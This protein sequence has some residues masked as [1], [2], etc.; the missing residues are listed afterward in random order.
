MFCGADLHEKQTVVV[1]A[2]L[3]LPRFIALELL[4]ENSSENRILYN[5]CA[6]EVRE[7]LINGTSIGR[8]R[9]VSVL[10]YSGSHYVADVLWPDNQQKWIRFDGRHPYNGLGFEVATPAGT[11]V[12]KSDW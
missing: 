4:E 11:T 7:L 3:Q 2:P 8:Y 6:N 5:L 1:G 10:L 12:R 9:L